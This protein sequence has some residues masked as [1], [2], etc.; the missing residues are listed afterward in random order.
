MVI[1]DG[2]NYNYKVMF[3]YQRKVRGKIVTYIGTKALDVDDNI[4]RRTRPFVF[5]VLRGFQFY[6]TCWC[7]TED[8]LIRHSDETK[9]YTEAVTNE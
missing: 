7:A 5:G 1:K 3:E 2:S 6:P 9:A 4:H 8:G